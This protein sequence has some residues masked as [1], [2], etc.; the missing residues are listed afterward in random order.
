MHECAG[1]RESPMHTGDIERE[2]RGRVSC[3]YYSS[4]SKLLFVQPGPLHEKYVV[5]ELINIIQLAYC[6]SSSAA[7]A[8]MNYSGLFY[9]ACQL[10]IH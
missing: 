1:D 5:N 10:E 3:W 2:G 4:H 7:E 9:C 8:M 6:H